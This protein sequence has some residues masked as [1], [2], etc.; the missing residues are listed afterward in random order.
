MSIEFISYISNS[1]LVRQNHNH[2]NRFAD[3]V[4]RNIETNKLSQDQLAK[5]SEQISRNTSHISTLRFQEN[6]PV[7]NALKTTK[8]F[9]EAKKPDTVSKGSFEDVKEVSESE[10][11]D[12]FDTKMES[13]AEAIGKGFY[14]NGSNYTNTNTKLLSPSNED[15]I[16]NK[17]Y[18]FYNSTKMKNNGKLVNLTF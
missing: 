3:E 14:I 10:K 13:S 1:T 17:L 5:A 11:N 16:R 6:M 8:I 2:L 7:T 18:D 9:N 12:D 4:N 15:F